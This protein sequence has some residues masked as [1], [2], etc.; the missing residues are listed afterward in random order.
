MRDTIGELCVQT[1]NATLFLYHIARNFRLAQNFI[2]L[3]CW[4]FKTKFYTNENKN[5]GLSDKARAAVP[6][7]LYRYFQPTL[8][9]PRG[10]LASAISPAA[11]T[12]ANE[13]V[14]KVQSETVKRA[15]S[16]FGKISV[17][18]QAAIAKYALENGNKQ[19]LDTSPS[20]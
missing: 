1:R 10:E 12:S 11:I 15:R 6:M 8:P 17:E 3:V 20:S 5:Y 9:S 4:R 2:I 13:A 7:A 14:K 18:K 16:Q 19:L